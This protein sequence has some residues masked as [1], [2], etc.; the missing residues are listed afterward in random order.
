MKS[1]SMEDDEVQIGLEST[2]DVNRH[3]DNARPREGS[4]K[5]GNTSPHSLFFHFFIVDTSIL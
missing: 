2:F 4:I 3:D 5:E 1:K